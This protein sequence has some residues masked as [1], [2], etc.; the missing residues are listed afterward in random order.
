MT[1]IPGNNRYTL[2]TAF[3]SRTDET[4]RSGDT[5]KVKEVVHGK[6]T[7]LENEESSEWLEAVVEVLYRIRF[8]KAN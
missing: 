4:D 6:W 8:K 3:L 7:G 1:Y 2:F 5:G